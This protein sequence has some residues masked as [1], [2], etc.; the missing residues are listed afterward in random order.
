MV[1][2]RVIKVLGSTYVKSKYD[3][4]GRQT[5]QFI[6]A[7]ANDSAYSDAD[8]VTGDYVME[9]D[10]TTYESVNSDNVLMTANIARDPDDTTT[11]GAL[12]TNAD[13][14]DLLYTATN[15]EGRIQITSNWYD[16]LER[17]TDTVEYGTNGGSNFDRDG[18]SVPARSDTAL[19]TEYTYN[20]DGS[21]LEI[22]D[23]K[24]LKTR[25]EYDD[26]GRQVKVIGN[27]VNGT[28]SG[29]TGADD[30]HT[31]FAYTDGLQTK[32]WVDF[33]GDNVEDADDEVTDYDF[34]VTTSDSPG[35][36]KFTV[37][38]LLRTV[39]YPDSGG[40]NDTV[41]F[42]YNAQGQQ[43]F[44]Q[45]Q[46]GNVIQT[47]YDDSGRETAQK[48]TTVDADFDNAIERIATVYDS[49]GR[50][51][52]VTQYDDPTSGTA[53][54]QVKFTYDGW[55]NI[56]L[57]EHD[58][59]STVGG[60]SGNA[61]YEVAYAWAKVAV[62]NEPRNIRRTDITLPGGTPIDIEYLS[63]GN[64]SF[65][66]DLSRVSRI[67]DV[68]GGGTVVLA[69]YEYNGLSRVV[70]V[71]L[72]EPD[73]FWKQ[74]SGSG[75][76]PDLDR[77]NRIT[78]SR[79]TKDLST[80]VDFFDMDIE[81][82]RNSNITSVDDLVYTGVDVKYTIDD[83]NRLT[84]A[85]EGTLGGGTIS[86]E[87]RQQ[88]WTLDQVG[89]WELDQLDLT[90]DGDF[91]D[92]NE[93]NDDRTHNVVN[94]LTARDTDDNGT[95]NYTLTYDEVGNLTD[96]AENFEYVYDP[97]GRLRKTKN[98]SSALVSEFYYNGL[99]HRT[100]VHFDVDG[101]GTVE[102]T[103]DDP[104]RYL[105]YNERWQLLA[106][107]VGSDADALH[108]W[109]PHWAGLFGSGGSSYIDDIVMR[110]RDIALDGTPE[111]RV[112]FCSNW[113][114]DVVAL[115]SDIGELLE[116]VRYSAYGTPFSFPAADTDSDFDW[117]FPDQGAIMLVS[118]V[119]VGGPGYTPQKDANLDGTVDS[120]DITHANSITGSYQTL[121]R[122][123]LSST[124][125]KNRKGY[126]DYEQD[127]STYKLYHVRHRVMNTTL[128]RWTRRDPLGYVDG[129][130][131]YR[132]V[133]NTATM[134]FDPF[135]LSAERNRFGDGMSC[136]K[137]AN[138]NPWE[139]QTC[140]AC[141]VIGNPIWD[142]VDEQMRLNNCG[143]WIWC[144]DSC[145]GPNNLLGFTC[146]ECIFLC[147]EAWG[148]STENPNCERLVRTLEHEL[149]H[150]LDI[151]TGFVIDPCSGAE[152]SCDKI[153]CA[154]W[155]ACWIANCRG[156]GPSWEERR[157]CAIACAKE[158]VRVQSPRCYR[159]GEDWHG[160]HQG[161]QLYG[162]SC[163]KR[164]MQERPWF[165]PGSLPPRI[166]L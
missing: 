121:G 10:Q 85:Q 99:N 152:E 14:D 82:D 88:T 155:R 91:G 19:L 137:D 48:A 69:D 147:P 11:T 45:D 86:S 105:A 98:Q 78:S 113:R 65:D 66:D 138:G 2:G 72:D 120:G 73:V 117:D 145:S 151:C 4:L 125:V 133:P 71:S 8:D 118:G 106:E 18:L 95:N 164:I 60:A 84:D 96:D 150:A 126:A 90:G 26:L 76:Y 149:I 6:L 27:Y 146:K 142:G 108:E 122:T 64:H 1:A 153:Y 92:A 97:W 35:A 165:P 9:E 54:D 115:L 101:D 40:A 22:A 5:H 63:T 12:D 52:T 102:N 62:S 61:E 33:D 131:L 157:I 127:H 49:L 16:D 57:Y 136:E 7:R 162:N 130:N 83:L 21:L 128:G 20:D 30:V 36:S 163:G 23:P 144:L 32:M 53:Q 154:E 114:H 47:V 166:I 44:R 158:R 94:E 107:F 41:R 38:H 28:P 156:Y 15:L 160:Q 159:E 25:F 109:M 119:G 89:N 59:D 3:R 103:A 37:N 140:P 79:W 77:F 129:R 24:N 68:T 143:A 70:N 75:S 46:S 135:G 17:I 34:G 161:W 56:T 134:K 80:D 148:G 31:R 93:L 42:A 116:Q 111:E 43:I 13:A 55:G 104:W 74:Y 124:G 87:T 139:I 39:E 58:V 51:S 112:Y 67:E 132:V 81:Y 29:V 141:T 50:T 100:E 123:V 110:L